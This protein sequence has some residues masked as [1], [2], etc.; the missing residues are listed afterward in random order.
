[1][2]DQTLSRT[3]SR[4]VPSIIDRR[5]LAWMPK[6]LKNRCWRSCDL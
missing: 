5:T 6:C 4:C 1:M 2:P 3:S